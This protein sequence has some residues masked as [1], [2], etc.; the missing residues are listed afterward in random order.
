MDISVFGLV[1]IVFQEGD[2]K[3]LKG[4]IVQPAS[5]CSFISSRY[6]SSRYTRP[7]PHHLRMGHARH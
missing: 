6:I 7:S 1:A 2:S 4:I 5:S 3:G